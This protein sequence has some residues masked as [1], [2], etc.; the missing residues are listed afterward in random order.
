M[1]DADL[2]EDEGNLSSA[3]N[4]IYE[5]FAEDE[6]ILRDFKKEARE[7]Q[8]AKNKKKQNNQTL[9]G[10]GSWVGSTAKGKLKA[11]NNR[12]KNQ[13]R[14][15]ERQHGPKEAKNPKVQK[16][17]QVIIN[18][19]AKGKTVRDHQ[20]TTMPFPFTGVSDFEASIRTPVG[21]TFI[22]RTSFKKLVQPKINVAK[23]A[24]VEP[25]D[26]TELVNRGIAFGD[27][28]KDDYEVNVV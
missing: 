20:P 15:L 23:G 5:A 14:I 22:P 24:I 9:P 8:E 10:W 7:K 26:K 12:A 28:D 2:S 11:K 16:G 4:K 6:D 27:E 18:E 25:V 17:Y 13:N 1:S 3:R 21:D 19:S